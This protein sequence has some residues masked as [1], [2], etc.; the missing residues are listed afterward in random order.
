MDSLEA[1]SVKA[2]AQMLMPDVGLAS[3]GIAGPT[4]H[5]LASQRR[6]MCGPGAVFLGS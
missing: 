1:P 2:L 6:R 5:L 3:G 4:V